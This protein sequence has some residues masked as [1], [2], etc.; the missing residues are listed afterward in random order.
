ML[1]KTLFHAKDLAETLNTYLGNQH[2][3]DRG[4]NGLQILNTGTLTKVAT[5]VST[6]LATIER[7]VQLNVHALITHHAL[8]DAYPIVDEITYKKIALLIKHNIALLRYHLPLDAHQ[9]IGN[10][11]KAAQD[12]GWQHLEPFGTYNNVPIGVRGSFSALPMHE[13]V[14]KLEQYYGNRAT[15]VAVKQTVSS[16]ALI[17]GGGYKFFNQAAAAGVDCFVTGSFDEPAWYDA[18][19]YGIS[20]CALGHAATEKVGPRAM[21]SYIEQTYGIESIFIDTANPF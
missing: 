21:A 9:T 17:S 5:A 20:F 19:E 11:W 8:L 18:H 3:P 6:D 7:A 10:N 12:L 13:F 16:A 14:Q 1:T 15:V 2:L 4:P